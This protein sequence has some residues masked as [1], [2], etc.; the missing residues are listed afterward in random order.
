MKRIIA[1]LVLL[2]VA[3]YLFAA[4]AGGKGDIDQTQ[5]RLQARDCSPEGECDGDQDQDQVKS[6]DKD[7][8]KL[9]DGSCLI[10]VA[11]NGDQNR[12]HDGEGDGPAQD[13]KSIK[14]QT[15]LQSGPC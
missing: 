9:R 15:R 1:L 8:L 13:S 11:G 4:P 6:Q 7:Q 12:V 10:E 14:L 5:L 2:I 3:G